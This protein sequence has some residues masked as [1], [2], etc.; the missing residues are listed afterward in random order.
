MASLTLYVDSR[1]PYSFL[2]K[3][4]AFALARDFAVDIVWRPFRID[5]EAAYGG[6]VSN[7]ASATGVRSA[8]CTWTRGGSP[9]S[10]G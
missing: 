4:E 3:D 2:A 8:T 10:A 7:A 5:I 9:R 1:S 6:T